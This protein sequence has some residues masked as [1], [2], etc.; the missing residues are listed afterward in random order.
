M[1]FLQELKSE[2]D[3]DPLTRGYSGMTDAQ[4]AADLNTAYRD[5]PHNPSALLD[6]M[7]KTEFRNSTIYGRV[8]IVAGLQPDPTSAGFGNAPMG[9]GGAAVAMDWRMVAAAQALIRLTGDQAGAI[10][11]PL[12]NTELSNILTEMDTTNAEVMSIAQRNAIIA[13]SQNQQSR[14]TE[15]GLGRVRTGEVTQARAL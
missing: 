12:T 7:M 9:G 3:S 11:T 2:I 1:A 4:V 15:L 14:A 13:L 8:G 5:A 6:Y 10:S